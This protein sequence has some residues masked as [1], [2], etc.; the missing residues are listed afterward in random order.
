M[1]EADRKRQARRERA[2]YWREVIDLYKLTIGCQQCGYSMY[3]EALEC[4]HLPGTTKLFEIA[5]F[6]Q[7]FALG[8]CDLI[9]E[10]E[11]CEVLCANC[12]RIQTGTRRGTQDPHSPKARFLCSYNNHPSNRRYYNERERV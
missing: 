4:D 10:L 8:L 12:H 7:T 2:S 3:S 6:P 9:E 1:T 5:A 11:K